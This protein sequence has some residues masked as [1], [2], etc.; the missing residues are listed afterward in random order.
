MLQ[1]II[2]SATDPTE[3]L[4]HKLAE[5]LNENESLRVACRGLAEQLEAAE[6]IIMRLQSK[7]LTWESPTETV[8]HLNHH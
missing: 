2:M 7:D 3:I 8:H 4:S 1:P 6:E 5:A